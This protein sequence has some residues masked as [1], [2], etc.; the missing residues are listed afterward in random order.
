MHGQAESLHG[1]GAC[2]KAS[3]RMARGHKGQGFRFG[4]NAPSLRAGAHM[5][6]LSYCCIQIWLASILFD[7]NTHYYIVIFLLFRRENFG[8]FS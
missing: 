1:L 7:M 8:V 4:Y 3:R 5:R 6:R 2:N